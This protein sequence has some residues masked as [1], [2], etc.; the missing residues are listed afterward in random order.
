MVKPRKG[1]AVR[2]RLATVSIYA[3]SWLL[4]TFSVPVWVVF[5]S[6]VGLIRRRSFIVLRLLVFAWFYFGFELIALLLVGAVFLSRP[7]GASRSEALYRLQAWWA[8]LNLKAARRLLRLQIEV[9]GA[10]CAVPGPAILLIRHASI[11]DTLLPCTYVQ[12]PYG[13]RVRYVLKQELLFDP[14]IDIVGNALPNYFIDRTGDTVRELEG[15]RSLVAQLGTDGVLIFPEGT[16]FSQEKRSKALRRLRATNPELHD[17]AQ[18]MKHV[19]PPKPGGALALLDA[20]P[21]TDC[22]FVAHSGLEAF[23]RIKDLMSGEVV[24]STV[25]I[26]MW[27]VDAREIPNGDEERVVWLYREWAKVDAFVGN[28]IETK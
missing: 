16:R 4:L 18:A 25:R 2:R 1:G 24:G 26:R 7:A 21:G 19:L 14:C 23:A 28:Q 8:S 15:I 27:R 10:R 3:L 11:L 22:V 5:G 17:V 20:L 9:A 13:F 12:R 6:L